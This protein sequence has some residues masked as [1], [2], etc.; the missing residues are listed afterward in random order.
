LN[1]FA[2]KYCKRFSPFV[3]SALETLSN[4]LYKFS[5]YLLT[6]LLTVE[7][8]TKHIL[9]YFFLGH[10]V[11][12]LYCLYLGLSVIF[13][14]FIARTARIRMLGLHLNEYSILNTQYPYFI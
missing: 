13:P 12:N 10:G 11:Y 3:V 2:T 1:K 9:A 6:Y 14:A 8:M 5:T 7:D 4:A